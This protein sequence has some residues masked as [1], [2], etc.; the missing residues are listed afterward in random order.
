MVLAAM[1]ASA[2][3]R[4]TIDADGQVQGWRFEVWRLSG[5]A[6][7]TTVDLSV[8]GVS[9]NFDP[10]VVVFA[11]DFDI[12]EFVDRTLPAVAERARADGDDVV[13]RQ[14]AAIREAAIAFDDDSANGYDAAVSF[15][16][17]DGP[18]LRIVVFSARALTNPSQEEFSIGRYTLAASIEPGA[19]QEPRLVPDPDW[20]RATAGVASRTVIVEPGE[21]VVDLDLVDVAAGTLIAASITWPVDEEPPRLTLRDVGGKTLDIAVPTDTPGHAR[22]G[23]RTAGFKNDLRVRIGVA[24]DDGGRFDVRV[25]VD[26]SLD[27]PVD[28]G[29]DPI[30]ER[31][32]VAVAM[33]VDQITSVDQIAENFGVVGTLTIDWRDPKYAFRTDRCGCATLV[34]DDAG[35]RAFLAEK[36]ARQP[37]FV[38]TNQ[39]GRRFTHDQL[40]RVEP[41]GH[42]TFTERFDG[43]FQAPDFDFRRF[44]FDEQ[45]FHIRLGLHESAENYRLTVADDGATLGPQ[46][47]EEQWLIT[48]I[49]AAVVTYDGEQQ[50]VISMTGVRHLTYYM[51][52][53]VIPMT[54]VL[55]MSWFVFFLRDLNKRIDVAA[56]NLL[57][58]IAINF[59]IAADLPRLGYATFLD[60]A[61]LLT[62]LGVAALVLINTWL[63]HL[64][65]RGDE[66]SSQPL[67]RA[68]RVSYPLF[69]LVPLAL[70]MLIM[71]R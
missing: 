63:K 7:G 35:F 5:L 50:M 30:V 32:E 1:L 44:P 31:P 15:R 38:F 68:L 41:S 34:L 29:T 67:D 25:A 20:P 22:L 33:R 46:L 54:V 58:L 71:L 11:T 62:F 19:G 21:Q 16:A 55:F 36:Q 2:A 28:R 60:V 43:T 6:A 61:L 59:S 42:V 26:A 48:S 18:F 39:Q 40:Y 57:L 24:G 69:F 27:E 66:A 45:V 14:M 23:W 56:G 37:E 49:G 13:A 3:A 10:S 70:S 9:G 4:T 12:D 47:G 53:I 17:P 8:T 64:V 65:E 51:V 52:R